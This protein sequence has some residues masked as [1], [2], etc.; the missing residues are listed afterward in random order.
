MLLQGREGQLFPCRLV[1]VPED[2][3]SGP[4]IWMA[5][6]SLKMTSRLLRAVLH[7]PGYNSQSRKAA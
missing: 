5:V 2:G 6:L 7:S 4:V 1:L 3:P